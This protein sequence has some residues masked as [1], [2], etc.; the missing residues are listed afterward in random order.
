MKLRTTQEKQ[1]NKKTEHSILV[2]SFT[3]IG[4]M[5]TLMIVSKKNA[6]DSKREERLW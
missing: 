3:P 2:T 5:C 6:Y 1:T 4:D